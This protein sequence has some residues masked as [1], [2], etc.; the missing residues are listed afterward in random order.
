V[1]PQV[2]KRHGD[3]NQKFAAKSSSSEDFHFSSIK[4]DSMFYLP[5]DH[6]GYLSRVLHMDIQQLR[7]LTT[8]SQH[9]FEAK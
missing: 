8:A 1:R 3:L 2:P 5:E 9:P 7:T 6:V 4:I